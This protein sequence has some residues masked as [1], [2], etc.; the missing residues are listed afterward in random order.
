MPDKLKETVARIDTDRSIDV[1]GPKGMFLLVSLTYPIAELWY[2]YLRYSYFRSSHLTP[3]LMSMA[4]DCVLGCG[5]GCGGLDRGGV[6]GVTTQTSAPTV[7]AVLRL[8]GWGAVW[9]GEVWGGEVWGGLR[10]REE[11]WGR[12]GVG[13]TTQTGDPVVDTA[14]GLR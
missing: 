9:G 2:S 11:V 1:C 10:G 5:V 14:L 6:D 13:V 7:E 8:R 12:L 3:L 4:S